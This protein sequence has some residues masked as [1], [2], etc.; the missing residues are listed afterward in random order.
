M[1]TKKADEKDWQGQKPLD[2]VANF[3]ASVAEKKPEA[4]PDIKASEGPMKFVSKTKK[5]DKEQDA[6]R[7]QANVFLL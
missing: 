3:S 2:T 4:K 7:T 6:A 1:N 5:D